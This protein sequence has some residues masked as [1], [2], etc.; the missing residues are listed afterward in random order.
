MKRH[1]RRTITPRARD[2]FHALTAGATGLAVLGTLAGSGL[3][4]GLAARAYNADQARKQADAADSAATLRA[5]VALIPKTV[6]VE[7]RRRHQAAVK[8][9]VV[10][11]ASSPGAVVPAH[12][13]TVT[14]RTATVTRPVA[15]HRPISHPS[16]TTRNTPTS[17]STPAPPKPKSTPKP[18][19]PLPPA[20]K[21]APKPP[22]PKPAPSSGS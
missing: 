19:P 22:P 14:A 7:K 1:Q 2:G 21:P 17:S 11:R 13:G 16:P 20:P 18:P 12:G 5:G 9:T 15:S 3:V 8:A 6:I 10:N 4:A